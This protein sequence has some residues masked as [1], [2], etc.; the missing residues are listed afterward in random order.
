MSSCTRCDACLG[1]DAA[2]CSACGAPTDDAPLEVVTEVDIDGGSSPGDV[3]VGRSRPRRAW[4]IA[5]LL[6]AAAFVAVVAASVV[7]GRTGGQVTS[8]STTYQPTPIKALPI[9]TNIDIE[10]P[11]T[12]PGTA[13]PLSTTT[14]PGPVSIGTA[15]LLGEPTGLA[16]LV[17]AGER[18]F[19]IDFDAAAAM[20]INGGIS[21]NALSAPTSL[22][23][24]YNI[25]QVASVLY[26]YDGSTARTLNV[27][28]SFLGEGPLGR[29]WFVDYDEAE[30]GKA[31]VRFVETASSDAVTEV[32]VGA[33][34]DNL[35]VDG[36]GLLA[37]APGG[38][39]RIDP[40]SPPTRISDGI[41][42]A[43]A[44]NFIVERSCDRQLRC[45][46]VV[47]DT[48]TGRR[49]TLLN[50]L[51][52][53][54]RDGLGGAVI[55]PDGEWVATMQPVFD[56]NVVHG[57]LSINGAD[58]STIDIG[59]IENPCVDPR[60]FASPR[61]SPD[62]SWLIGLRDQQ[63]MWAWRPGLTAPLDVRLPVELNGS[64]PGIG[65]IVVIPQSVRFGSPPTTTA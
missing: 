5:A 4:N 36:H 65:S 41:A 13:A 16:A 32:D 50:D 11:T 18:V 3:V 25:S 64:A 28:G 39:Y 29:F 54:Q 21:N 15:P 27:R 23:L 33:P 37:V 46:I 55:S 7:S 12:T 20:P 1:R 52:T 49:R 61:W 47:L 51:R 6:V 19:R 44:N 34:T 59:E 56:N 53:S 38:T 63:T 62:G 24:L 35:F 30:L 57:R 8:S 22:G 31:H 14:V 2:F 17:V 26:P 43:A 10:R 9:T 40:P 45:A 42:V 60:C 58:G 48:R